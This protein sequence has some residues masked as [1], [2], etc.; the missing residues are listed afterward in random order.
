MNV[1]MPT[2]CVR[3]KVHGCVSKGETR[4]ISQ[5]SLCASAPFYMSQDRIH[6]SNVTVLQL[7]ELRRENSYSFRFD[8]KENVWECTHFL[9][10]SRMSRIFALFQASLMLAANCNASIL[11]QL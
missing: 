1:D 10:L 6:L 4:V 5:K 3:G 2:V 9:I 7:L 11:G 8:T